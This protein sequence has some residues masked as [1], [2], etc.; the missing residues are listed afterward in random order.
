MERFVLFAGFDH[1]A[2]G[3]WHDFIQAFSTLDEAKAFDWRKHS[4]VQR[5]WMHIVDL[6]TGEIVHEYA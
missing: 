2:E 5:E 6:M 4:V 1:E 3:G